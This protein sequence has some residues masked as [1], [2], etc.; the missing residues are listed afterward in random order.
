VIAARFDPC[1]VRVK[2]RVMVRVRVR[3][4]LRLRLRL[5]VRVRVRVTNHRV[6]Q[7]SGAQRDSNL[8]SFPYCDR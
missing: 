1:R 4:R 5:R 8:Q 3:F 2:V 6:I 7:T